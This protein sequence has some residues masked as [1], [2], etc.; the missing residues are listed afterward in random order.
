MSNY[1]ARGEAKADKAEGRSKE[2]AGKVKEKVGDLIGDDEMASRGTV[3]RADGKKD[4]LKG[5][6]KDKVEDAK[7]TAKA[8]VEAVKDKLSKRH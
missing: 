1:E 5:E 4:R 8:G 6:I 2:F 7:D 3:R